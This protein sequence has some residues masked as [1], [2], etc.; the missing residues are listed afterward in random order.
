MRG[1]DINYFPTFQQSEDKI[2]AIKESLVEDPLNLHYDAAQE[3][4]A[5]GAGFYKFSG[6]EEERRRQM[7]A[8]KNARDDTVRTREETGAEDTATAPESSSG[9]RAMEKRKRDIEERRKVIEAKRRKVAHVEPL[10]GVTSVP[11][12]TP[13]PAAT[14]AAAADDP[15][16][17]LEGQLKYQP[18]RA[19]ERRT[20]ASAN[21]FSAKLD[22]TFRSETAAADQFLANLGNEI[23]H[24]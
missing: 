7:D 21:D 5:K 6:D 20:K 22:V 8:L 16:A 23:H 9:S 19:A 1:R 4:R 15:F 2:A 10:P 13:P 18:V 24:R 14:A 3:V 17:K 11:A 12:S